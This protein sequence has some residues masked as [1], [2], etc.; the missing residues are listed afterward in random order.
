MKTTF[1]TL[2]LSLFIQS[3]SAQVNIQL[4]G[5]L[6][7]PNEL[8]N[9]WGYTDALGNEYA[10]VGEAGGL[11]IVDITNP[12]LP[13]QVHYEPDVLS[14]WRE[15][16]EWKKHAFV[17]TEGGGGMM[18]VDMT[19]L[20]NSATLVSHF[21][22]LNYAF[23]SAHTISVDENGIAYIFGSDYGVGGAIILDINNPQNPIEL[24]VVDEY[25]IH[26]GFIRGD[27]LWASCIYDGLEVAYDVSNKA[28][29]IK[30][31]EW[32]TPNNFTHN[33]AVSDDGKYVFT[34]DEVT[35]SYVTSY[36]VSDFSNITEL[37]RYQSNPGS[38]SI[39]HNTYF[40]NN[41]LITS[42]YR[43][44]V[45]IVDASHPNNL[46]QVGNYDSSPMAGDG[47]NGDWG[48]YPYF[49]SGNIVL[50]DMEQGLFILGPNYQRACYL[51][52]LVTDSSCGAPLHD[53]RVRIMSASAPDEWSD[54]NGNYATGFLTA[55]TY[56][57]EFA[58]P[59][60]QT[61][62]ITGVVLN[63]GILTTL[64]IALL[65]NSG[66]VDLTG[67]IQ[68]NNTLQGLEN[69]NI[70]FSNT[71][72]AYSFSTDINGAF[73]LCSFLPGIYQ[74][75]ISKWGYENICLDNVAISGTSYNFTQNLSPKYQD[76]FSSNLGWTVTSSANSGKWVRAIPIGTIDG[77]TLISPDADVSDDCGDYAFITGNGG[78]NIW[79]DDVDNGKTTLISPP[80]D[81]SG[82]NHPFLSY[83]YWFA[84]RPGS[85][86]ATP[87]DQLKIKL[88][89]QT[90]TVLIASLD[91]TQGQSQWINKTHAIEGVMS[92][93]QP[94]H[95][96]VEI[97]DVDPGHIL[98]AG[99]DRFL[100][101]DS[102]SVKLRDLEAQDALLVFPNP[103]KSHSKLAINNIP[104]N[105]KKILIYNTLGEKVLERQSLGQKNQ[106]ISLNEIPSGIYLLCTQDDQNRLSHPIKITLVD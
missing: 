42:Y 79:T 13:I 54:A 15:L 47:F 64:N 77:S 51:E 33:S 26:D 61:K 9:I 84:T 78:G 82:Y 48:V 74:V 50:S 70:V 72:N 38:N 87:N 56:T 92:F 41:Y 52:G 49:P 57:I 101:F 76:A 23:S 36:D 43:D 16:K 8:S 100:I 71:I 85:F 58:K 11:S 20:P 32:A 83:A 6:T 106:W 37:D 66:A 98:E 39:A 65:S 29:P 95:L 53:V 27:T 63:N 28:N 67:V 7:Y 90:D 19:N 60:Y 75:E 86:P 25:Y 45:T 12:S 4:L 94:I 40:L 21:T 3:L 81:L 99:F 46:I 2:I 5:Q 18:I 105:T 103:A 62:S 97:E 35:G 55:G 73:D 88:T 69:V 1:Y 59:G 30:I 89:N 68:D 14:S 91:S 34:T 104:K 31:A 44:G 93:S 22:G 10:L 96:L 24:G 17:V 80:M 102:I